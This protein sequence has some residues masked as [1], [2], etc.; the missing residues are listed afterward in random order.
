[1]N[2]AKKLTD[3]LRIESGLSINNAIWQNMSSCIGRDGSKLDLFLG[4]TDVKDAS[5]N[6]FRMRRKTG[7]SPTAVF[8]M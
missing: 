4:L 7:T 3:Q 6:P 1:V 2:S 5:R 8:R